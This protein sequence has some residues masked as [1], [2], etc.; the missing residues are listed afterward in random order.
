MEKELSIGD[1]L[2]I[3]LQPYKQNSVAH[4]SCHK[5]S[6]KYFRPYPVEDRIKLPDGVKV[7]NVFH[8]SQLKKKLGDI[9]VSSA[10]LQFLQELGEQL[11]VPMTNLDRQLVKCFNKAP[12]RVLVQWSQSTPEQASWEYYDDL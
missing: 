4:Q 6:Y 5:L 9:A 3:K 12:V 1:L 8:I 2:Y 10:W 7:H 11:R